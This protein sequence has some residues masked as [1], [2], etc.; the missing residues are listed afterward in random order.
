MRDPG[1]PTRSGR[2]A[3]ALGAI[4]LAVVLANLAALAHLVTTNPIVLNSGLASPSPGVLPGV[5]YIDPNAGFTSQALGHLAAM[6]W[7]HG[8]VPWW[9]PYEGLGTPL[10]A[11]MQSGAFFP[12]TLLLALP[13]GTLFV[14]LALE[15]TAGW[16]TYFVS[17]RLGVGAT[18]S[19]AAGVAYGLAGTWALLDHAPVRPMEMLPLCLL[20]VE[21]ALSFGRARRGGGWSL[22]AAATALSVLAGFPESTFVD[23]IFMVLWAVLR[24]ERGP[25]LRSQLRALGAGWAAGAGLSAP[26]LAA[27]AGYLPSAFIGGHGGS[28]AYA[29]SST[30]G[31]P[32]LLL[33][34]ALGPID[35]Y[36]T[37]SGAFLTNLGTP[38]YIT[39]TVAAAALVGLF[40]SRMRPLR[41]GLG[42]WV[43]IS[44]LRTF[45]FAPVVHAMAAVP[46][47]RQTAFYLWSD[48]SWMFACIALGA[49]GLDDVLRR[50]TPRPALVGAAATTALLATWAAWTAA[51]TLRS[52]RDANGATPADH[53]LD[54]S[55][56][57]AFA[58]AVLAV[59]VA[60]VYVAGRRG[61]PSARV[62]NRAR[63]GR[64]LTAGAVGVESVLLFSL[65]S[66]S[67][68]PPTSL[69]LGPVHWLQAHLDG[70]R[71]VTL[72]PIAPNYGSYFD[73]SSINVDDLPI[74]TEWR[75]FVAAE[76]DP[77]VTSG[78]FTGISSTV[79]TGPSPAQ[80][81]E[82]QLFDYEAAGVRY[83]IEDASG[84]DVAGHPFPAPGS[85]AWPDGPR[86]VYR[87]KVALIW[88]LPASSPI[89]T[90]TNGCTVHAAGAAGVTVDCAHS[91]VV[92]RREL[93]LAG[94]SVE[95]DGRPATIFHGSSQLGRALEKVRVP[96]GR[97]TLVFSYLPPYEG[98]ALAALV[99]SAVAVVGIPLARRRRGWPFRGEGSNLQHPAPKA[100]VLPIELPRTAAGAVA[101]APD[102][103]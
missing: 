87:D 92:T 59:L 50:R 22:L 62:L 80:A 43:L 16:S 28:L 75:D 23:T 3:L 51:G 2:H 44:L 39:V 8:H 55:L 95:V 37:T 89:F 20:G 36:R 103:G 45:G 93:Y 47:L 6:D 90:A 84:V 66:L 31:L 74:P 27:F 76:L 11:E 7:L 17:R 94:W 88:E 100:D 73:I 98:P 18:L 21:R 29:S 102:R 19:S 85:P 71:Y 24:L 9:N 99:V 35:A 15:L 33:P 26:L 97:S 49:L 101:P 13:G 67:A 83:V 10:A 40:G 86:L 60:G 82:A 61:P 78:L 63:V 56:S 32:S 54:P 34:Y 81:L 68:P 91:A 5:P 65:P 25:A 64:L 1:G 52:A 72:G 38:G 30:V 42:A 4:A 14:Q 12:T 58:L 57:L 70:Q 79:A 53:V 48:G 46:G 96:A 69:D 77:N 41:I